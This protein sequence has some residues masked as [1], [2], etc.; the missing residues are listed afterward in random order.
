MKQFLNWEV[1]FLYN[2]SFVKLTKNNQ[3]I[4]IHKLLKLIKHNFSKYK[5]LIVFIIINFQ[6]GHKRNG[7]SKSNIRPSTWWLQK[8]KFIYLGDGLGR[9]QRES[10]NRYFSVQPQ[11]Q[12]TLRVK[13]NVS[14]YESKERICVRSFIKK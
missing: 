4:N 9:S 1:L 14:I 10:L 11:K 7:N 3:D 2:S 6:T 5:Y 12:F 13:R 8:K